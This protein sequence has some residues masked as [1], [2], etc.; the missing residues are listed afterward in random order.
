MKIDIKTIPL[1][2][3]VVAAAICTATAEQK[4]PSPSTPNP[5]LKYY[6]P[7]PKAETPVEGEYDVVV[8]GGTPGGVGAAIQAKRMGKTAALYVFRRHVGG[9]TSAGLTETDIGKKSAIG[10]MAVEFYEK[11]GKW[12]HFRP[13]EAEKAFLEM[14]TDAGV[15]VFFEHRLDKVEK[16]DGKIEK[17]IFENGNSAKGKMF[18]D[19]TYEGDLLAAAGVSYMVGREDNSRFNE[20]YNGTY[21]SKHSH[22]PR[23]AVDPY[24]IPGDPS[25]GLLEGVTDTKVTE[26]GKGDKKLQS[27]CFRMWAMKD[28]KHVPWPKPDNYRPERYELLKRYVNGAPPEFWDLRYKHGPLKLNEGDCNNAGPIS[29]DHVGAN[30][31]WAEGTYAEREKIFQDHVNYQKGF[32]YFLANDP[33][34]PQQLRERVAAFGLDAYEFPET[35]NWPHELYVREARRLLS[36]YVMTQAHCQG[37]KIAEDSVGLG[38]YQMDSHHVERVVKDGKL[39]MEGGFEKR[40]RKSYPV[41]YKSIVPKKSECANLLVPVALSASHVAFGSIRM[42]PVFMILG[43]SAATAAAIAIDDSVAVQDV[44]YPKLRQRLLKDRQILEAPAE[45]AKK[46][47]AKR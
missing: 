21:F 42:E 37:A 34:I 33:S 47:R 7:V 28:G 13:S 45:P 30:F 16:K 5:G 23:H 20:T 27:Y 9:L 22:L 15:P 38:S 14:L 26:L 24:K 43:Q 46:K 19:A 11:L 10:G 39:A 8:Y 25:S 17:I 32:M 3:L 40:V 12:R 2:V 44:N 6:Y 35:G 41:S 36:D 4:L 18:I 1:S 31:G 29:L